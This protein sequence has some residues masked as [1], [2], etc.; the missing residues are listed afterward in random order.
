LEID[1][2]MTSDIHAISPTVD[3]LMRLIEGS[4]CV[5]G[6]ERDV[7]MTLREAL[8]RGVVHGSQADSKTKVHIRCRCGPG[9]EITI[10]VT[11]QGKGFGF[12]KSIANSLASKKSSEQCAGRFDS[13]KSRVQHTHEREN[14]R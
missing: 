14:H 4:Q 11:H 12:G 3:R 10:V 1:T 5:R 7:E 6:A 8:G 13:R 9:S 2:W